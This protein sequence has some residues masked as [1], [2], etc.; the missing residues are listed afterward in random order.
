PSVSSWPSASSRQPGRGNDGS[1][2]SPENQNRGIPR[3]LG[4]R[5]T[6][7]LPTFP[8]PRR[9]LYWF[10]NPRPKSQTGK[11]P[12]LS[13]SP[14]SLQAHP[15]IGKDCPASPRTVAKGSAK[16]GSSNHRGH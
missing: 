7:A 1:G 12:F 2:K 15:S 3:F 6:P 16:K 5:D 10:Q 13:P 11:E 9:L 8:P 14:L 4:K